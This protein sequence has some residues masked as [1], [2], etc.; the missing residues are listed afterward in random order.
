MSALYP[1]NDEQIEI[2]KL[3]RDFANR[4]IIPTRNSYQKSQP[5][6][7]DIVEKLCQS[8]LINT[9]IPAKYGGLELSLIDTCLIIEELAFACPGVASLAIAS[10]MAVTYLLSLGS[11][12]QKD[13]FLAPLAQKGKL[14]GIASLGSI[15]KQDDEQLHARY[16][17]E[18]IVLNG[19]CP[20]IFNAQKADWLL[21]SC[22][23]KDTSKANYTDIG[24]FI[25]T[26]NME[27]LSLSDPIEHIGGQIADAC[28]ARFNNLCLKPIN[29]LQIPTESKMIKQ[30][31]AAVITAGCL[32]LANS[33][34]GEAKKY[35]QERQT[36]GVPIAKHQAISFMLADMNTDIQALRLTLAQC[37]SSMKQG[38][39][40]EKLAIVSQ[41]YALE[42]IGHIT[43]DAVQIF[44]GYGYTKEY[45]VEKLMRDAKAFQAF[46]G[47]K[48]NGAQMLGKMFLGKA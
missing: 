5:I 25:I 11:Q 22:P 23:F 6:Q 33:A 3:A 14:G 38:Y 15:L 32:G 34:F 43:I 27:G 29:C 13:V 18:R 16:E 46:Y 19:Y 21:V 4:E 8:G 30:T 31:N 36:F 48:N 45:P 24:I 40:N 41:A 35:S 47:Q 1:L 37:I 7:A 26:K 20:L 2:Q 44:G 17:A 10:E 9:R 42:V 28:C 12:E 39:S